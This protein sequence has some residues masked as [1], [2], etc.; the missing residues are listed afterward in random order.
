M[1][2]KAKL[3]YIHITPRKM[4]LVAD[5]CKGMPIEKAQTQLNFSQKRGGKLML[6]LLNSAVANAKEKGGVDVE[7]LYIKRVLVD[8]GPMMKR[9]LPRAMGRAT[10]VR[11][12][13][14]HVTLILDEAR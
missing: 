9:F 6:T 10:S 14:S 3:R 11:K 12:K 7:N 2:V 13:M 1:E 8:D 4:R 5:L